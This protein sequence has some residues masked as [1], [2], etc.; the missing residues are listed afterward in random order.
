MH[1]SCQ[2][3][4][5]EVNILPMS[6]TAPI[7][8]D[9]FLRALAR[10]FP[11]IAANIDEIDSGL[12]HLEMAAVSRA[13]QEAV[14]AQRWG[15]AASH[16]SFIEEVLVGA[17]ESIKNA[18]SVSYLENIFLGETSADHA[19]ARAMLPPELAKALTELEAHFQA[20]SHGKRDAFQETPAK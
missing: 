13:T 19:R 8:R 5:V 4:G 11:E 16:F 7:D 20:L 9:G 18:V 3:L 12:P 1:P 14:N 17:N 15:V 2:T 6:A 10:R